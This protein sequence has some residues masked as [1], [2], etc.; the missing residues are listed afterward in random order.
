V[1]QAV[2]GRVVDRRAD[3][4]A[5]RTRAERGVVVDVATLGAGLAD[6]AVRERV[7]VEQ[8]DARAGGRAGRLE[9][10][11]DEG[12]GGSHALDLVGS[13]QFDHAAILHDRF[14]ASTA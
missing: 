7:E 2:Q 8:V 1:R 13:A 5:E 11:G 3:H 9:H 10:A 6:H 12:S 4:L 14:V